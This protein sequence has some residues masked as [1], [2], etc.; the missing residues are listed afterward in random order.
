M[1]KTTR[2]NIGP[3]L[4]RSLAICA[5]LAASGASIAQSSDNALPIPDRFSQP[6]GMD[7]GNPART[8]KSVFPGPSIGVL[9]WK[10]KVGGGINGIACDRA[11]RAILGATFYTEWWSNELYV[12]CYSQFGDIVW[13][14]KV[15][16]YIWGGSQGV[17]SG[18][19]LDRYGNSLMNSG[20][21]QLIR[22]DGF[23]SLL[24]TIQRAS[25]AMNDS[26]P[27]WN[28]DGTIVHQQAGSVKKFA[29]NGATLWSATAFS[30]TDVAVAPN[31]DVAMGGIRTNEPHGAPDVYY[32]NA[33]GTLRWSRSSSNGTRTQVC[34]GPDGTLYTTVGGVTAYNPDG[35]IRWNQSSSGWGVCL[36]GLGRALVPTGRTIRAFNKNTGTPVWSMTLPTQGSIV[37]GLT[38]DSA[39]RI[40]VSTTDGYVYG[41]GPNGQSLWSLLV[42]DVCRTQP[43]I[44]AGQSLFV[45]GTVGFGDQFL[46]RIKQG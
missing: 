23:G 12:Q 45:A 9:D 46:V 19:A 35:T 32:F 43:A 4:I 21:G 28:M 38:I 25:N 36:D 16:P 10:R 40:Y 6:W 20:Y 14:R 41:I 18:P 31:G 24:L 5:A 37:E 29:W 42:A 34:F 1:H 7:N 30:D 3:V 33:N 22:F 17:K 8:G 2:K 15:T 27:A 26:S 11:G 13:R 39:N 44:G